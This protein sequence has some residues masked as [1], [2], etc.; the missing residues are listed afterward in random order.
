M[1]RGFAT[2]DD[3]A[4]LF[5]TQIAMAQ[6]DFAAILLTIGVEMRYYTGFLTG[7]LPV[8][9]RFAQT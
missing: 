6:A 7:D 3:G 9:Y 1:Q 8:L 2:A 4:G 5:H